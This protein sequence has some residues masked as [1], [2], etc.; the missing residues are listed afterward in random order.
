VVVKVSNHVAMFHAS[1][2]AITLRTLAYNTYWQSLSVTL[3]EREKLTL[4]G[5]ALIVFPARGT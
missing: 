4:T 5:Q 1:M 2:T 3:R